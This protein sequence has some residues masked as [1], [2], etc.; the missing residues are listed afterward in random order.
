MPTIAALPAMIRRL[1]L[2]AGLLLLLSPVLAQTVKLRLL[3]TTDLH[4]DLLDYD[5][6]QDKPNAEYGL[7]RT[8][9]LIKQARAEAR[10]SL[11]IDNGDLLQG[12]PMGEYV[13]RVKPLQAGQ[14]HP[15]FKVMNWLGYDAGNV[16]NHDF[17]YGLPFLR[18]A[19]AGAA[20]PIVN[21]N[22][23]V[24]EGNGRAGKNAF[25]PYVILERKFTDEAG[26]KQSL[27][28]GVVG[29]V[30]P[31][32]MMWDRA[33]L[34]GKVQVLD[35]I[36]TARRTIPEIRARGADIVVAVPHSGFGGRDETGPMAEHTTAQ[37]AELPGVDAI[38]FG[39]SHSEFPSRFFAAD[40]KVDLKRGTINGI[41]ATNPNFWGSHLGVIDLV[42]EKTAAGWKVADS[43][44]ELRPIWDRAG[45]KPLVAADPKVAELLAEEHQGTLAFMRLPVGRTR[46]P[47]HTYFSLV[48]DDASVQLVS[49]AQLV[50]ARRA[51][52]GTAYE[53]LPLL[54][55]ASPFKTGP[56]GGGYVDIPAGP[57]SL[58]NAAEIYVY[59]NT[60]QAVVVTG[61]Q[62]REWLEMSALVYNRIDPRG[63]P[64]QNLINTAIPG[65]LLDTI[66]GVSY[67]VD[68]TQPARYRRGGQL[69]APEAHRI[70]DLRFQ[71]KP[72]DEQARFVVVT[73]SYRAEG[74]ESFP[75]LD[76]KN[77][78]LTAPDENREA[79]VQHL[80]SMPEV[81]PEADD[82]WRIL[83][84]PGVKLH[85]ISGSGGVAHLARS[86]QISLVKDNG[87]GSAVYELKP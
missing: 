55:S 49:Q 2:S 5:Y 59:P 72:I 13:A 25:T 83:P 18:Q 76:G 34:T 44:A 10:N 71:G 31:Q 8:A 24:D 15:A 61:A 77:I 70:K 36:E 11:L 16:G 33:N 9:T 45:R 26:A 47:I 19:Q 29:F 1:V 82:N 56:R 7:A 81:D 37:I 50:Y 6:Y 66:D 43:R 23:V 46:T 54:S 20:F 14:V 57:L 51:L 17:N 64:E 79:L 41:P 40:P 62:V 74:G 12:G 35:I 68:V 73:N 48:G 27:K 38:L 22:V 63:A 39:H 32:I 85:F 87:D 78:V 84:V 21:A 65:Y 3:E 67:R 28:V 42:I 75:G 86:P 80:K 60:L 58:R 53:K 52:A 4:M 69:V 30:P